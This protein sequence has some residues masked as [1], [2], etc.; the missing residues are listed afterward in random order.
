MNKIDGFII[1]DDRIKEIRKIVEGGASHF[2]TEQHTNPYSAAFYG[3]A[4]EAL[5]ALGPNKK[6]TFKDFASKIREVASQDH[7]VKVD[8]KTGKKTNAWQRFSNREISPR[9]KSEENGSKRL[10]KMFYNLT[11]LQRLTGNSPYGFKLLQYGQ[12]ILKSK[13]CTIDI[14]GDKENPLVMLNTDSSKP[15]NELIN[16]HDSKSNAKKGNAKKGNVKKGTRG[17]KRKVVDE[18]LN[19]TVVETPVTDTVLTE[20]ETPVVTENVTVE[21]PVTET[22]AVETGTET[23]VVETITETPAEAI[24]TETPVSE[25]T[26]AE[27]VVA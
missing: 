24:Q 15:V 2:S 21:T 22:P 16:K 23:P 9:A 6:H 14:Y 3:L 20:V 8:K 10:D 25:S 12:R 19:A 18:T 4:I 1:S 26:T 17:R 5:Y 11:V 7:T 13:G 27:T